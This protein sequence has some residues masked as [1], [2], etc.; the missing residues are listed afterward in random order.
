[1]SLGRSLER[2]GLSFADSSAKAGVRD[3]ATFQG[4]LALRSFFHPLA[5]QGTPSTSSASARS[6][7]ASSDLAS[8]YSFS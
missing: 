2:L 8:S 1:M 3:V 4:S 7:S 5:I 6:R